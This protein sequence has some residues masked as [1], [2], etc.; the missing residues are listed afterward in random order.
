MYGIAVNVIRPGSESRASGVGRQLTAQA[1]VRGDEHLTFAITFT[2]FTAGRFLHETPPG[3][4]VAYVTVSS[5]YR[6]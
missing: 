2:A 3:A 1:D 5:T 4:D 6:F